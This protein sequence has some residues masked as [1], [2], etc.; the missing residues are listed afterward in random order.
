[1][2]SNIGVYSLQ[3]IL[4]VRVFRTCLEGQV[5]NLT[6]PSHYQLVQRFPSGCIAV[7]HL[8]SGAFSSCLI[9]IVLAAILDK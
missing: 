3:R 6:K 5:S 8:Y 1:M 2:W 4:L 7:G 9:R